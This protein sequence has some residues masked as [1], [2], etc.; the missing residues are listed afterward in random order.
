MCALF[1]K[2]LLHFSLLV[3]EKAL[4]LQRLIEELKYWESESQIIQRNKSPIRPQK[5]HVVIYVKF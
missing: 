2:N 5:L 3:Q 1:F 4:P